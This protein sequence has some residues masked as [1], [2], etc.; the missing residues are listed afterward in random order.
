MVQLPTLLLSK[1][2]WLRNLEPKIV[3]MYLKG[4][5]ATFK[6]KG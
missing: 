5:I 1:I 3:R 4:M 6:A 2:K